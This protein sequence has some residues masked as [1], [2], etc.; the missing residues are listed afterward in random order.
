MN[1]SDKQVLSIHQATARINIWE[2]AVRSGKTI[3]SLL[4]WLAYIVDAPTGGELVMMGRTKDTVGRNLLTVLQNPQMMG[5]LGRGITYTPGAT[6]ARIF[7]R[8]VHLIGA[9][10]VQSEMKIRGMTVAGAYVDEATVI[11]E[12][13]WQQL[14][15]RMS[16]HGAMLFA[17]TNPDSPAHWL[18]RDWLERDDPAIR[19]WHFVLDDNH[20]LDPDYVAYLKRQYLGLWRRRFILGEWVLAEG[21]VY[22]MFDP[23]RHV[24]PARSVP[25]ITSWLCVAV[26]Y[27]TTNPFHALVVGAGIDRR[28]YVVD[29]WRH[30]S[31]R[32]M[33]Q[34]TDAQYSG[35]LRAWMTRI[36]IPGTEIRGVTP[37]YVVIDPSATS[38]RVQLFQDGVSSWAANNDVLDGIRTV[39]TLLGT[40]MLRISDACEATIAEHQSYAWDPK[41]QEKGEDKPLKVAD[42]SCDALRYGL[43]TTEGVWRSLI[44]PATSNM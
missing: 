24:V 20:A 41:A 9:N 36:P 19:S 13:T 38:F 30:D 28:L 29:E 4:R 23:D 32:A 31:K 44:A 37:R 5:S 26:D 12:I 33:R 17:T 6:E 27:G 16:V 21:S 7:G 35:A 42:H 2:G 40:D 1:L 11:P 3:A 8:R 14:V 10:D 22:D 34:M 39:S 43:H 18:K 25:P 15:A